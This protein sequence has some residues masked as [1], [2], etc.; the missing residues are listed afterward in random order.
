MA[1]VILGLVATPHSASFYMVLSMASIAL[2]ACGSSVS[3]S[4]DAAV[5]SGLPGGKRL[6]DLTDVEKGRLCDWMVAQNGGYGHSA[7]CNASTSFLKYPDQASCVSDSSSATT[8][9]SCVA[10]VK[11]VEDC[12]NQV[13]TCFDAIQAAPVCQSLLKC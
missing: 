5:A 2:A 11:D 10:T 4:P 12:L 6:I 8:T 13:G 9:P 7:E 1:C 3:S